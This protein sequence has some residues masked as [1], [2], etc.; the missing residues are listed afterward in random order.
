[1]VQANGIQA[2]TG[3]VSAALFIAT[4]IVGPLIQP[5]LPQPSE[6]NTCHLKTPARNHTLQAVGEGEA[7][8]GAEYSHKKLTCRRE[9]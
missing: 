1:M 5:N 2:A 6:P 4:K 3:G 8:E 7:G 9:L